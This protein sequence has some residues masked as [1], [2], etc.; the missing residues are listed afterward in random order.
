MV[1]LQARAF[2]GFILLFLEVNTVLKEVRFYL[3]VH[4]ESDCY[5]QQHFSTAVTASE[6]FLSSNLQN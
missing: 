5:F 1:L 4:L 3:E 6:L 2:D